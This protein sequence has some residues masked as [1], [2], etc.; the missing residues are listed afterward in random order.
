V[1]TVSRDFL[2][3]RVLI[4]VRLFGPISVLE[5][6]PTR[7]IR[8]S[9]RSPACSSVRYPF[10]RS[11]APDPWKKIPFFLTKLN[12]TNPRRPTEHYHTGEG[13]CLVFLQNL[14]PSLAPCGCEGRASSS[15][16]SFRWRRRAP[17]TITRRYFP[18]T[19]PLS[20]FRLRRPPSSCARIPPRKLY[21][22]FFFFFSLTRKTSH[23]KGFDPRPCSFTTFL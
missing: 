5:G 9:T 14:R 15:V 22:F 10:S 11:R 20:T 6:G 7:S 1:L 8:P 21:D 18:P 3:L 13:V 16:L 12:R 4:Y 2:F 19:P 23:S 17:W